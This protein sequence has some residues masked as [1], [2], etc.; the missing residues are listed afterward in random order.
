MMRAFIEDEKRLK[1]ICINAL[2]ALRGL[3]Y[4][5]YIHTYTYMQ[6]F[7]KTNKQRNNDTLHQGHEVSKL[8][9]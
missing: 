5:I 2:T 8:Y 4:C 3:Y 9:L 1:G 6:F 7:E